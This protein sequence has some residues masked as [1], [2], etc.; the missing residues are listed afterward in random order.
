MV[1]TG[2]GAPAG[3]KAES[4]SEV[5]AEKMEVK[6]AGIALSAG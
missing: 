6:H 3:S 2:N 1:V 5:K 4:K